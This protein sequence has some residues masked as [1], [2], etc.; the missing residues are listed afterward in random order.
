MSEV[1]LPHLIENIVKQIRV[2]GKCRISSNENFGVCIFSQ[3]FLNRVLAI[4]KWAL[5]CHKR[6]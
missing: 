1:H 2:C 6:F 3:N 4:T 5:L